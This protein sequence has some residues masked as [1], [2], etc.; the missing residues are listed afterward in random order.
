M[1]SI[2]TENNC[3][4]CWDSNPDHWIIS[5][6]PILL[7]LLLILQQKWQDVHRG[8]RV[9]NT[10]R[11]IT[12]LMYLRCWW[13]D[14]CR[15]DRLR[16]LGRA[17]LCHTLQHWCTYG[18]GRSP[19]ADVGE[20]GGGVEVRTGVAHVQQQQ[21]MDVCILKWQEQ[22]SACLFVWLCSVIVFKIF[23]TQCAQPSYGTS[24]ARLIPPIFVFLCKDD[25]F[26]MYVMVFI[27]LY[28]SNRSA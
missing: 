10:V 2:I 8:L 27:S 4:F 20:R 9:G 1:S 22:H 21:W 25:L 23:D 19:H 5:P 24:T 13:W 7:H 6:V 11:Y 14:V 12:K 15:A 3:C 16:L 28:T 26:C 18:A 17:A